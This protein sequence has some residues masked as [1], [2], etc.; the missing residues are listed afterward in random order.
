[1]CS[2][3]CFFFIFK[4]EL[5]LNKGKLSYFCFHSALLTWEKAKV[6]EKL[7]AALVMLWCTSALGSQVSR[8][9]T[10]YCLAFST[11]ICKCFHFHSLAIIKMVYSSHV[12]SLG[13]SVAFVDYEKLSIFQNLAKFLKYII[14]PISTCGEKK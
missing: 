10:T 1:M 13:D 3:F 7:I 9:E 2:L 5:Y 4:K 12:K 6:T 14:Y 8:D 11:H